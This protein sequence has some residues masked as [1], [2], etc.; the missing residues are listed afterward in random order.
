[1]NLTTPNLIKS[2]MSCTV[3]NPGFIDCTEITVSLEL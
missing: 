3:D 1:M 2:E